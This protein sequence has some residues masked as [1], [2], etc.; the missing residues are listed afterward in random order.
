MALLLATLSMSFFF[1]FFFFCYDSGG[2]VAWSIKRYT[3][4]HLNFSK[5]ARFEILL[6]STN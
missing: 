6:L 5:A 4:V 1:F 2:T 3:L